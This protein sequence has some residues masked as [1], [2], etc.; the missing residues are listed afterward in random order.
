MYVY[1]QI[2]FLYSRKQQNIVNHLYLNKN[3]NKRLCLGDKNKV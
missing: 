2:I 3:K 1:N